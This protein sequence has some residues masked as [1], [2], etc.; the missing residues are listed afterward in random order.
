M[1]HSRGGRWEGS[2]RGEGKIEQ[3]SK[4]LEAGKEGGIRLLW[5]VRDVMLFHDNVQ[6]SRVSYWEHLGG[7]KTPV[8]LQQAV[9]GYWRL[10]RTLLLALEAGFDPRPPSSRTF[11]SHGV[12]Q[13][14]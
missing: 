6:V 8:G 12:G 7:S 1:T 9:P 10:C 14:F 2:N 4:L 11:T 3:E 13:T 5:P